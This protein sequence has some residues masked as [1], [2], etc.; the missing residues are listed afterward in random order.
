MPHHH[1]FPYLLVFLMFVV[2]NAIAGVRGKVVDP[3][4]RAVS[5]AK[6]SLLTAQQNTIRAAETDAQGNFDLPA[7]DKT[8]VL[9][10]NAP[11]FSE[12]RVRVVSDR[13][14]EIK[15]QIAPARQ[16]VTVTAD[17]GR[18]EDLSSTSQQVNV[19]S[20]DELRLRA[21]A[22]VAQAA[23]EEQGVHL[24]RTSPTVSGI[25]V[26]GLTGNRVN[27]F[28]DGVRY[29]TSAQRGGINTFLN[30]N[31][32][33]NLDAIEVLRG[34]NSAQYGSDSIG[35][36]VQL[37]SPSP[38]VG[39]ETP[40]FSGRF[41]LRGNTADAGFGS[42]TMLSYGTKHV[43]AL[44]SLDAY[45]A[46]R[47]YPGQGLDSHSAFT[48]FFGLPSDLF[49]GSRLPDTAFTQYGGNF[50]TV[51]TPSE[52]T[53]ITA[54]YTRS[55]QDGGRRYD[56]LLGGDGNLIADLR[57][58]M[59]DLFYVRVDGYRA[60]G[61]DRASA[62]YSY[63]AQREE[64][65]NQGG[66]GNPLATITHEPERTRA[67]GISGFVDKALFN[68]DVIIGAEYYDER[69]ASPSF[70]VNPATGA[71]SVRRG[72]VPDGAEYRSGGIYLQDVFTPV[73]KLSL[74]GAI[75]YSAASYRVKAEPGL[76][77]SD[78]LRV[79]AFTYRA[80]L[81]FSP[82]DV[83]SLSANFSRGFRAPHITDLGTLGLT[84]SG[85][86]VAAPDVAGL[87]A[88]IGNSAADSA[89]STVLPVV[90]LKPEY[91]QNYEFGAR[92]KT[93]LVN[94][95]FSVFVN[96]IDDS[97]TKQA[98]ILPAGAVG[99]S[100]GGQV[101]TSQN[102]NGT[103]VVAAST[104][105]VLVRANFDDARIWGIEHRAD[106]HLTPHWSAGT[107]FTYIHA[108]D[109]RTGLAPNFEGGTPA[110]DGYFRIRYVD[111]RGRYWIEPYIHAAYRQD[112]LSSL[113]L[114]DRRTGATR[115]RSSIQNF[116]RRG[117][118]VRGHV[119]PGGDGILGN[120]DDLLIATGETLVQ[121]QNRVLGSANS[122]PT[123]DHVPGYIT[124]N[125]RGG[126]RLAERH[127]VVAEFEN[128]GD[129]NYRGISWG[130]DAPGR[131]LSLRYTV[132][133]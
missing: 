76:W 64:R 69:M 7:E 62:T 122:A 53:H 22:V 97:I 47:L 3:D 35:G 91:S 42:D 127:R 41:G 36:T 30:M 60:G 48:R 68:N 2:A 128:I 34:P 12:Q 110:P 96:D 26:R 93:K 11:G 5:G 59:M 51:W 1:L 46:N 44:L 124:F 27:V 107:V 43:G 79:D 94:T 129:R 55:Q 112:R 13:P 33:S 87:N 40:I 101:I 133:F 6:V 114:E 84:G 85:F 103:V 37:L 118:T 29:S 82:V 57:N 89:V 10:V 83:L 123:Y 115:T 90:Q 117:A 81:V 14:I 19:I 17:A 130:V 111:A 56:Q 31:Q 77:P 98:L 105:P 25:F 99:T 75:R 71:V 70:G 113:D 66:N 50:K 116:F 80:G 92:L 125:L 45:R 67:H 28:V 88:T 126:F 4:G 16:D 65:V 58:L 9:R 108:A 15:L 104:S 121:I 23:Q 24:Q 39:V 72:R 18:V 20:L 49:L 73:R 32:A 38:V 52:R 63:N 119:A 106:V 95:S 102:P 21:K 74:V 120:A 54:N 61:F 100:L 132:N 78:S 86:E 8:Y 131:S 109:L